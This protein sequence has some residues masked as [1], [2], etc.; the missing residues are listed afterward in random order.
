MIR[1]YSDSDREA[2]L[3]LWNTK[4]VQ[5]GYAPLSASEFDRLFLKHPDFSA[6]HTFVLEQQGS[7]LGFVSGCTGNHI[8]KGDVR[9]Y[10]SCLILSDG[11]DTPEHTRGLLEALEEAFR[12]DGR[13]YCAV[14][15][16][17]PIHLPWILPG[18]DGHQHN[19]TPGI[20]VDLPLYS[21]MLA[22]G[23]RETTREI[24]MHLDLSEFAVPDRIEE[25]A[26]HMAEAGYTV[27]CYDPEKHRG[28]SEMLQ[29]LGNPLWMEEIPAAAAAG[30]EVLVGLCGDTAAGF[31]GPIFPEPSGRG[32][33]SGIGV[34]P[35]Y[36]HHGLGTLLF[37]R[38]CAREKE[39]G[40]RYMSLFTG[41]TNP[42]ARIYREAGFTGLRTFAVMIKEL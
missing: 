30:Q 10:L 35:R 9:G 4:G 22:Q 1:A 14:T 13:Q 37:Y 39:A 8:P 25:K 5:M 15:F 16:F 18:T 31:T 34:A 32:Y 38:L 11:A 26:A 33:F 2:L 42:A 23:Y 40:A 20:A 28:L 12:Q 6:D 19:N 21:R 7:V 27:T 17:N 24:A 29:A 3:T 41:E 36:E